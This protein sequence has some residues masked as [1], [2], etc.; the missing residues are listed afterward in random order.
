VDALIHYLHGHSDS[1]FTLLSV[2]DKI[3][4]KLLEVFAA[5]S[6]KRSMEFRKLRLKLLKIFAFDC[7][8][9]GLP[10]NFFLLLLNLFLNGSWV[11]GR[12]AFLYFI[13]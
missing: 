9:A 10:F 1:G 6:A 2:F 11:D 13:E 8:F 4:R 5:T 7:E 3:L 12:E